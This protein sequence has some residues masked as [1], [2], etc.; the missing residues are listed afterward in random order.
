MGGWEGQPQLVRGW[1]ES[2]VTT[3]GWIWDPTLQR[4]LLLL[5]F[6]A[7]LGSEILRNQ[8]QVTQPVR[9]QLPQSPRGAGTGV[10][11]VGGEGWHPH[12][13]GLRTLMLEREGKYSALSQRKITDLHKWIELWWPVSIIPTPPPPQ[14]LPPRAQ[15]L[16]EAL[17]PEP[18]LSKARLVGRVLSVGPRSCPLRAYLPPPRASPGLPA[19][20]QPPTAQS[21]SLPFKA[22]PRLINQPP[23]SLET[24]TATH[25]PA[26]GPE[27]RSPGRAKG[28]HQPQMPAGPPTAASSLR[29]RP[30]SSSQGP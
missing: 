24:D 19:P 5:R 22:R 2:Q 12:G 16:S 8:L 6:Q 13:A 21:G 20:S 30:G 26:S 25:T 3:E 23:N 18:A 9:E 14:G 27:H 11:A 29:R 4:A 17:G 15:S 28:G 10:Q 1:S 7:V